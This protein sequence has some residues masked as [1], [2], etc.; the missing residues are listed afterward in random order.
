MDT[1]TVCLVGVMGPTRTGSTHFFVVWI[2]VG[3]GMEPTSEEYT[4]TMRVGLV[5]QNLVDGAA[6]LGLK[7]SHTSKVTLT[8]AL[9]LHASLSPSSLAPSHVTARRPATTAD[10]TPA[11][12]A[13]AGPASPARDRTAPT[14]RRRPRTGRG[15]PGPHAAGPRGQGAGA[16][17]RS[18]FPAAP[19]ARRLR[20]EAGLVAAGRAR[21]TGP[22]PPPV[23]N[24]RFIKGHKPSNHIRAR[25]KSHV[26]TTE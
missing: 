19:H 13:T 25:I 26:Y 10:R 17:P 9:S 21:P 11:P 1:L 2:G 8:P 7:P 4:S 5:R 18:P 15:P 14:A 20:M 6:L 16:A 12:P 3:E 22:L 24:T 23:C